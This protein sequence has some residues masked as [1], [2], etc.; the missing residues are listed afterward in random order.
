MLIYNVTIQVEQSV[1]ADWLEWMQQVH[2]P[3][4][5]QSGLFTSHQLCRLLDDHP[6]VVTYAVQYHCPGMKEIQRYQEEFAP[7]LQ[8]AHR[9]RYEGRFVAFRT[10]LEKI[11]SPIS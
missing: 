8:A 1:A 5:L 2:I 7:G 6:D 11:D 10:L 3:E 4:V 9:Q